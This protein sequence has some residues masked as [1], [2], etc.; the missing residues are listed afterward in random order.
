MSALLFRSRAVV[1]RPTRATASV[2]PRLSIVMRSK[3]EAGAVESAIKLADETCESG[4]T[5]ECAAAWDTVEEISAEIS[6]KKAIAKDTLSEDPLEQF[7]GENP[8]A[9]EC[10]VYED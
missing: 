5:G 8:D 7:C 3:P 4:T 1:A 2:R 10:R 9:D 6:H